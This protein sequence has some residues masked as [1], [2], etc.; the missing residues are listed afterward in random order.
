MMSFCKECGRKV[1]ESAKFCDG[2]G[3][4]LAGRVQEHNSPR[5]VFYD[6]EIHKC[7]NC[8]ATMNAFSTCCV[9]CGYEFRGISVASSVQAFQKKLEEIDKKYSASENKLFYRYTYKYAFEKAQNSENDKSRWIQEKISLISA[10]PI[11]NAKEDILEFMIL[12]ASNF[13]SEYYMSHLLEEDISDAWLAKIKQ[14]FFKAKVALKDDLILDE[15]TEI[16]DSITKK[17]TLTEKPKERKGL[18]KRK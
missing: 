18:F 3:V 8:G 5:K 14:C 13:D 9:D 6:G 2:C 1:K 15:I 10:F 16:Y 11:P 7:P 4:R 12:A 17:I